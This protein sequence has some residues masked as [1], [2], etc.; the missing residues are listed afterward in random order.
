MLVR[1]PFFGRLSGS[2]IVLLW[3][4]F[5]VTRL[6]AQEVRILKP[7]D[8]LPRYDERKIHYGFFLGLNHSRFAVQ[9]SNYFANQQQPDFRQEVGQ[10]DPI[11]TIN[12]DGGVGFNVGFVLNLRLADHF[13][14][15]LTPGVAFYQRNVSFQLPRDSSISQM[16]GETFSFLEVP[17]LVKFKSLRRNNMRMY[18]VAGIKPSYEVGGR[19]SQTNE[20]LIRSGFT[21]VAFEYGFGFDFYY[22][23]FKFAPEIR[24]SHGLSNMLDSNIP[25]TRHLPYTRSISRLYTHTVTLYLHF[26]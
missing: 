25:G 1:F 13:D 19:R 24:F 10:R 8:N 20:D 12:G 11:R 26:E 5:S 21:D 4:L 22:P 15:R 9:R 7:G 3:A 23:M 17:L 2:L 6:H 16:A 14:L 18:M